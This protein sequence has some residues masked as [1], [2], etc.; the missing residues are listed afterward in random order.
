MKYDFTHFTDELSK[1][2]CT[3]NNSQLEQFELYYDMLIEKN[4]VMN[5]TAITDFDEVIEKHFL[6]SLFLC[7]TLD[8]N[9]EK[10][11]IDVGTG[12]GFPGIPLKI[13]FPQL[14]ITLLDSLNKRVGFL[15]EVIEALSLRILKQFM[16]GQR[17]LP[18]IRNTGQLMIFVYREQLQICLLFQNTVCRL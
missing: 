5:L 6:D 12:A 4:K 8:L 3:L 15:N 7:H 14:K 13:A 9:A 17:I 18:G 11:I 2:K 10:N 16:A 1:I